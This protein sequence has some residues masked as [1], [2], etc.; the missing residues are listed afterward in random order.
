MDSLQATGGSSTLMRMRGASNTE[1]G[2]ARSGTGDGFERLR[3][4]DLN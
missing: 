3:S 4:E 1:I 2:L